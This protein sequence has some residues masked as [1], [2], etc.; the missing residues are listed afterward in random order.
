MIKTKLLCIFCVGLFLFCL[1]LMYSCASVEKIALDAHYE[2]YANGI[3]YDTK[4]GLDWY[5][6]PDKDTTW[7]EAKRWVAG[8]SVDGGGWRMPTR[9]E[10]RAIHKEGAGS[11][12]MTPLLK[13]TGWYLWSGETQ[14]SK[15]A[16]YISFKGGLEFWLFRNYSPLCRVFAV[17]SRLGN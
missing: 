8:L 6:D 15:A 10:L 2:K 1:I 7:N 12:N 14:G 4:T 17:R 3:V 16:W 5:A 9:K 11:R 13:T